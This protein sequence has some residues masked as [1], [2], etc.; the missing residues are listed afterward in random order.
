VKVSTPAG[1]R[2]GWALNNVVLSFVAVK[3]RVCALSSAGPAL[4]AVAEAAL[5][6]PESSFTVT[7]AP[8]VKLGAS[9]T[10]VTVIAK[11][12]GA[13]VSDPPFAVPPLSLNVRVIVALPFAFAAGVYVSVPLALTAG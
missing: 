5:Y 1:L 6:A 2:A 11:V 8:L 12:C 7:F 4:I 10:G 9:F 13:L 3:V